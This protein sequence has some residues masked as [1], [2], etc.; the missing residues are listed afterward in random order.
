MKPFC[1]EDCQS[2]NSL[3]IFCCLAWLVDLAEPSRVMCD[4]FT[5]GLMYVYV[6]YKWYDIDMISVMSVYWVRGRRATSEMQY[7]FSSNSFV[8][9]CVFVFMLA[10]YCF[11]WK[12]HPFSA[13]ELSISIICHGNVC[14][15]NWRATKV[16][17]I[18]CG[19]H[20][21]TTYHCALFQHCFQSQ[22]SRGGQ[23]IHYEQMKIDW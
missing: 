6:S 14:V 11:R 3:N 1:W 8:C 18:S 15:A 17:R 12:W 9:V 4:R 19:P 5:S 23:P 2:R 10:S 21:A 20:V 22:S 7:R 16:S 13:S